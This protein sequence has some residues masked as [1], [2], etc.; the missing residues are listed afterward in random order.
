MNEAGVQEH[1]KYLGLICYS[2]GA[3]AR[4]IGFRDFA[5]AYS[6]ARHGL[7]WE[8]RNQG[9]EI[10]RDVFCPA[11]RS[12]RANV[13]M[14]E[15]MADARLYVRIIRPITVGEEVACTAEEWPDVR[16]YLERHIEL[17]FDQ[18]NLTLAKETQKNLERLIIKYG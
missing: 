6:F 12:T 2:C 11:C 1:Q 8:V 9:S 10:A 18:G 13:Y 5:E 14:S 15:S 7:G 16:I 3:Y 17:C 4:V